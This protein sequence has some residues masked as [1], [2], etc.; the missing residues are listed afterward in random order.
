MFRGKNKQL[1]S[2][3]SVF[4]LISFILFSFLLKWQPWHIRLQVPLFLMFA[5]PIAIF[6]DKIKST[7]IVISVV[8]ISTIYCLILS[9]VNPNRPLLKNTK[10][11]KL[12]TRFEKYFVSMPPY[13]KEYKIWRYK[14]KSKTQQNWDVHADTWEYPIYYDCFSVDRTAFKAINIQN[15]TK[16]LIPPFK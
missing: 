2:I 3:S 4:C 1:L 14:L 10:Q 6:L 5:I 13:S 11:T 12:S 9:L 8:I 16:K 7:K 15:Q